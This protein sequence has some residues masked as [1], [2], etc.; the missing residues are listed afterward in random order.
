M[1]AEGHLDFSA[2]IFKSKVRELIENNQAKGVVLILDT[3]KKFVNLMDKNQ[4]SA[5]TN[6]I[7]PFVSKGGTVVALAHTNKNPDKNGNPVYGG[8][9]DIMNDIDCAYTI[10][11]ISAEDGVK[12]VEFVNVKRRGNVVYN[13]SYSYCYGNTVSYHELLASVQPVDNEHLNSLKLVEEIKSDAEVI[14]A[15][16][17]CI[18]DGILTKLKLTDAVAVRANVSKRIAQQIIVKYTGSDPAVHR[19]NF[20]R[21]ERGAQ[22][23][24]ILPITPPEPLLEAKA[25]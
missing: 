4:T 24:T 8:V 16:Q 25:T 1:L 15:V 14:E 21:G 20:S 18:N 6:T 13:A 12:I 17:A 23:F 7:R 9:S 11:E 10:E 3:L 5:F 2:A 19:W 22:Q